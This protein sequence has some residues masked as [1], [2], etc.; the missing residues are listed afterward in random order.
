MTKA[1]CDGETWP[2]SSGLPADA[3][4][5]TAERERSALAWPSRHVAPRDAAPQQGRQQCAGETW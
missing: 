1:G 5:G 3:W 4:T 2:P